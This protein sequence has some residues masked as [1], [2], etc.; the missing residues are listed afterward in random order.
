MYARQHPLAKTSYE[1]KFKGVPLPPF[2]PP[3][4]VTP[5]AAKIKGV[6]NSLAAAHYTLVIRGGELA[7]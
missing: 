6:A 7:L 5:D 2:A 1:V 4:V 3:P